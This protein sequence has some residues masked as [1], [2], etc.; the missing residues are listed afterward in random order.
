MDEWLEF[1]RQQAINGYLC[2][3]SLQFIRKANGMHKRNYSFRTNIMEE[4]FQI[5]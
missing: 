4:I 2:S 5:R 1:D 3:G